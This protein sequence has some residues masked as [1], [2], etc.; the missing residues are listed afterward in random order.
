VF[1]ASWAVEGDSLYN[2]SVS[3]GKALAAAGFDVVSGGYG[4]TME[5]VSKGAREGGGCAVGVTVP[6]LFPARR[7]DGNPYLTSKIDETTLLRRIDTMM[8]ISPAGK[9]ALPGTLGTLAEICCAWNVAALAPVGGYKASKL[10]LW[11]N[12]WEAVVKGAGESLK[13]ATEVLDC[14]IFVDTV[15]EAVAALQ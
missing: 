9:I 4:G 11:R 10:I 7:A 13:L 8:D 1:G 12:P 6:T 2:L 14:I 5:G 3:L 15:E